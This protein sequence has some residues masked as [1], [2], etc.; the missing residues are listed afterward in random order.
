[1]G[2]LQ[3]ILHHRQGIGAGIIELG[4]IGQAPRD[5]AAHHLLEQVQHPAAIGQAQHVAHGVRRD[6]AFFVMRDR[7][8]QQRQ[9][10]ARRTFG[11]AGDQ[12]QRALLDLHF[13]LGRDLAQIGRQLA[14]LDAAQIET[15]AT[16]QHRHRH[17]A[18]FGGGE[19]EFHMR[20]RLFQGLQDGVEGR[21]GQHMHFVEDIDLVARRGRGIAHRLDDLAHFVHAVVGGRVHLLHIDIAGFRDG[22]AGIADAAGMDGGLGPLAVRA[23]AV[24]RAG[25]D[26]RG[27]G[28]A[29]AAHAGE[30]EGM[31]DAA[32]GEGVGQGAHQR[33]LPDQ[34]GE[35]GGAVFARQDA[36]GFL[37][38]GPRSKDEVSDMG[39]L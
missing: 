28:L 37:G 4:E 19:N 38:R 18:D 8:I 32:G 25:D 13:F 24:E 11:G 7:L 21:L 22:D 20:R 30:H 6:R 26:A 33:F 16:R 36:I 31:G 10:I 5:I 23:D 14:G 39:G 15:L 12:G 34:A 3:Q 1:M 27:G 17:L 9:R 29:H 35:I 2:D